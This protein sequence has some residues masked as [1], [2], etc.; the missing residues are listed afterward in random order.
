MET[1]MLTAVNTAAEA[2][3]EPSNLFVVLMGICIVFIG[4]ICI[5]GLVEL[6]AFICGKFF[7]EKPKAEEKAAPVTAPAA[8]TIENRGELVATIC[9]AVAEE[10]GTDISALRV[11]SLK[12]L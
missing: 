3:A 11:V 1:E 7:R 8:G 5:I 4:L 2:F 10:L 6:M 12:K 9:A